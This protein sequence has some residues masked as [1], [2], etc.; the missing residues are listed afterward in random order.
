M[1]FSYGSFDNGYRLV[2]TVWL[3]P[4]YIYVD[5]LGNQEENVLV[6]FAMGGKC[7]CQFSDAAVAWFTINV[8][9]CIVVPIN[10]HIKHT[11]QR[12]V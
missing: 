9:R 2:T 8:V 11:A 12:H 7:G 6:G 1:S 4:R 5:L 10:N 3:I